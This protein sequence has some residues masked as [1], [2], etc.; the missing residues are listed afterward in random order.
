MSDREHHC[1]FLNRCDARCSGNFRLDGLGGA[2]EYCFGQYARCDVYR[3]LL[4]ERR[5]RRLQDSVRPADVLL[6]HGHPVRW[7][8]EVQHG[9]G[10][11]VQITHG[12]RRLG[13]A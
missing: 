1:P 8:A 3:E 6:M 10:S 7:A 4:V 5:V 9:D 2:Y 13:A 11:F 12:G